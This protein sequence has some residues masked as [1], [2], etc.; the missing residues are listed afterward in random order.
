LKNACIREDAAVQ[1]AIDRAAQVV[2]AFIRDIRSTAATG[3]D[4]NP[5]DRIVTALDPSVFFDPLRGFSPP[6]AGG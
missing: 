3:R 4:A 2:I 1:L 5:H 6:L